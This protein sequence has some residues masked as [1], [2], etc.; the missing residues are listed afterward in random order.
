[1]NLQ[2]TIISKYKKL[3]P[4]FSL[5]S[6]AKELNINLSR[7]FRLWN[8][9]EMKL[10]EYQKI[11]EVID[12]IEPKAQIGWQVKAEIDQLD[13]HQISHVDQVVQYYKHVNTIQR[14][15]N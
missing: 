8:G 11:C 1:V 7:L 3:R 9:A 12:N 14:I 15:L 2:T 10:S 5:S 4:H 13:K 6:T